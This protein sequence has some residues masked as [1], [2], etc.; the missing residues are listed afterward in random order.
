MKDRYETLLT[1]DLGGGLLLLTLNRPHVAN[2]MGTQMGRDLIDFWES[3]NEKPSRY[4]C[5]VLTGAGEKAFSAG[6]D[7][8]ERKGMTDEAWEG[9]HLFFLRGARALFHCSGPGIRAA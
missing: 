9:P 4:R 3:V 8:K 1:E 2:A 5:I 7:L 6:G